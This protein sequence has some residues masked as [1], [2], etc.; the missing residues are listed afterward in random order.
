MEFINKI[1]EFFKSAQVAV[2]VVFIGSIVEFWLGK[3]EVVKAGSTIELILN[4]VK[5]VIDFLKGL[6]PKA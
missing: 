4:A 5:K 1:I 2:W 6:L 3:T